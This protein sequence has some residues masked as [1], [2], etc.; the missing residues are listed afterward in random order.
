M[1]WRMREMSIE[2]SH[3]RIESDATLEFVPARLALDKPEFYTRR[4]N[5]R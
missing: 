4:G 3:A 5:R 1:R 2:Q